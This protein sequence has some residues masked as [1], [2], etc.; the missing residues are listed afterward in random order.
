MTRTEVLERLCALHFEV[1][2]ALGD[3]SHPADCFCEKKRQWDA[4]ALAD[5]RNDGVSLEFIEKAVYAAL[6]EIAP[7]VSERVGG[8]SQESQP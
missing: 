1:A 7:R 5:Y 6:K 8:G 3:W 2:D 4:R